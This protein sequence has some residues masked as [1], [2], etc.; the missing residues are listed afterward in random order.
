MAKT[1]ISTFREGYAVVAA[2]YKL[3][4]DKLILLIPKEKDETRENFLKKV[5]ADFKKIAKIET[6]P[7]EVYDIPQI[8]KDVCGLIDKEHKLG[9]E[10]YVHISESRKT[11]ALGALFA[12]FIKKDKIKQVFYIEQETNKLLPMPLLNFRLSA[13][14][15]KILKEIA[16]G[17]TKVG[18][19]IKNTKK[20]KTLI[21]ND[22]KQLKK[23][24]YISEDMKLTDAGRICI[25]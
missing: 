19:I 5:K 9:N 1:L 21:Y 2:I 11:Q 14:K 17:V 3:E 15:T 10:I 24:G 23:E 13:T 12:G 6:A 25:L 22:I 7:T 4:P 16:G 8:V 18:T 20:S